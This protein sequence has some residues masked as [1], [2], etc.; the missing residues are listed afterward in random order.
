MEA[1]L[2]LGMTPL[3][4][5][6]YIVLPQAIRTMLPPITNF[7]IVL[8]KDT[9]LVFGRR[10]AGN[11]G[12]TPAIWSPRPS[13]A[14]TSICIAGAIYLCMTIPMA[15]LAARLERHAAGLA[16]ERDRAMLH[17]FEIYADNIQRWFPELLCSSLTTLK[18]SLFA[19]IVAAASG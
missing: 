11:H 7:S 14:C 15:R 16:I 12:A 17:C 19:F 8:L 4:A 13:R 3:G 6:R 2:S 10:R 9:A 5:M 18:L 1:A